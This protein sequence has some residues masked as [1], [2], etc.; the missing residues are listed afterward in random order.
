MMSKSIE[1]DLASKAIAKQH[2]FAFD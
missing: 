2:C 1:D